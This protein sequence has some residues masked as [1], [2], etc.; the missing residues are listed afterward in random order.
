MET[1]HDFGSVREGYLAVER[2]L[3]E[4]VEVADEASL[5]LVGVEER[6]ENS[7]LAGEEQAKRRPEN[8]RTRKT[9]E[10]LEIELVEAE[11][12]E[13]LA[14]SGLQERPVVEVGSEEARVQLEISAAA[15]RTKA[16]SLAAAGLVMFLIEEEEGQQSLNEEEEEE[17]RDTLVAAEA[18]LP[19]EE[20]RRTLLLFRTMPV[21]REE[22]TTRFPI[23]ARSFAELESSLG[24]RIFPVG[25]EE[26]TLR[27]C[28][29]PPLRK[30]VGEF[31]ALLESNRIVV[32]RNEEVHNRNQFENESRFVVPPAELVVEESVRTSHQRRACQL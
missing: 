14:S 17:W 13:E 1:L 9:A 23:L 8:D 21:A 30:T 3:I 28:S 22:R 11:E 10:A 18:R 20:R 32:D 29:P 4:A 6:K 2:E 25:F 5:I 31:L 26:R 15:E 27:L 12:E 24:V 16:I 7:I 19:Q